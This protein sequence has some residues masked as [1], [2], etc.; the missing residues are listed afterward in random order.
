[1]GEHVVQLLSD[2]QPAFIGLPQDVQVEA[3]DYPA[4]LFEPRV[5]ELRRQ[6]PDR[7][8]L[9]EAGVDPKAVDLVHGEVDALLEELERKGLAAPFP[10]P[11]PTPEFSG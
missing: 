6:R 10:E 1:M 8:E 5:H 9:E 3:F 7:R 2:T 4:R 11:R